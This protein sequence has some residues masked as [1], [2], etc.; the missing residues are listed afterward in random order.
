VYLPNKSLEHCHYTTLL[1]GMRPFEADAIRTKKRLGP[2][3]TADGINRFHRFSPFE[4]SGIK[5]GGLRR[6]TARC[7][8]I[9]FRETYMEMLLKSLYQFFNTSHFLSRGIRHCS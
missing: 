1:D 6:M 3:E 8:I 7:K 4:V 2:H 9:Y 5:L